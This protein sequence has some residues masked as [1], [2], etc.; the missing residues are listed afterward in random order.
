MNIII[1]A[2]QIESYREKYTV[3]ELDTIKI[4][5]ENRQVTAYCVVE[6]I[7]LEEL[8]Q[9]ESKRNLHQSLMTNYRKRDWNFCEQ[10]IEHLIGAWNHELDSF[11]TDILGRI[12]KYKEQDPGDSWD[13]TIEKH[14]TNN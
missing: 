12:A 2:E 9:V 5:P 10:A 8:P 13:G 1:D 11:Y 6:T 14:T 7:P 4:L 3:L